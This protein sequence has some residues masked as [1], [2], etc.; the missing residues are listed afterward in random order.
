MIRKD[1]SLVG[2]GG[3][4]YNKSG[5]DAEVGAA[6]E[7]IRLMFEERKEQDI[8]QML[9]QVVKEEG[10]ILDECRKR[11]YCRHFSIRCRSSQ[12]DRGLERRP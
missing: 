11:Q 10:I 4:I 6:G 7:L 9:G 12:E 2:N 5:F 1:K 8:R 3:G